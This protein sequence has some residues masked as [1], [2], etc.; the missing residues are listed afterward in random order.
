ME[1]FTGDW[2]KRLSKKIGKDVIDN[3]ER[4]GEGGHEK[5]CY[6]SGYKQDDKYYISLNDDS[7]AVWESSFEDMESHCLGGD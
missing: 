1:K 7:E 5:D 6:W 4:L 3:G 2:S